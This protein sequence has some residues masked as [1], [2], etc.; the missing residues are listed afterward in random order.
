MKNWMKGALAVLVAAG[1]LAATTA[2]AAAQT[3]VGVSINSGYQDIGYRNDRQY[4]G[5]RGYRGYRGYRNDRNYRGNRGYGYRSSYRGDRHGYRGRTR[6]H[7]EWR[8]NRYYGERVR[9]RIC[10]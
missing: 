8:Y 5:D 6:C 2:P 1:S 4:R 7:N 9:V 3:R 10:R